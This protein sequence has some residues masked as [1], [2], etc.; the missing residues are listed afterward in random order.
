VAERRV[1]SGGM[2]GEGHSSE[3]RR[4]EGRCSERRRSEGENEA[5]RSE[6]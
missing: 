2:K 4:S 5:W 6:T 1:K 3:V